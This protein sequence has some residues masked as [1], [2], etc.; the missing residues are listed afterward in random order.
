MVS[1]P[2][3]LVRPL[4]TPEGMRPLVSL[5]LAATLASTGCA[6]SGANRSGGGGGP[7]V[8]TGVAIG[9]VATLVTIVGLGALAISSLP[10]PTPSEPIDWSCE[11]GCD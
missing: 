3:E 6:T 5:V 9:V 2:W 8:G 11:S 1:A 10:E 7:G 4:Q